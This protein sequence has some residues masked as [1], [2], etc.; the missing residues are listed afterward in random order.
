[1][2]D[3][4]IVVADGSRARLFTAEFHAGES[5][6]TLKD[7][8]DLVSPER[9][10][11]GREI[12]ANVKSGRNREARNAQAHGYDDHRTRHREETE[13]RFAK[14]IAAATADIV[15]RHA[16]DWLV[17]VADPRLLGLLRKPL[18]AKLP[19]GLPR[20]ELR[21]DL[22]WHALPQIR[23]VLER[24]GVL[25]ASQPS[26]ASWRAR[27]QPPPVPARG[28]APRPAQRRAVSRPR[29]A[30][31]AGAAESRRGRRTAGE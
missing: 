2:T 13:R 4:C 11:T 3:W 23:R 20:I 5:S 15:K 29:R 14:Q 25:P 1:M 31:A 21:E 7:R 28:V 24:R 16:S 30:R 26:E 18:D 22:S 27:T 9:N 19:A 8:E 10:L 17:I 6:A 12:F